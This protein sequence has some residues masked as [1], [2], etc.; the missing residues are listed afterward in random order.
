MT[1]NL[2][3]RRPKFVIPDRTAEG[4]TEPGHT[5]RRALTDDR[6]VHIFEM[7]EDHR[8]GDV[9]RPRPTATAAG[10]SRFVAAGHPG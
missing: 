9:R 5:A 7:C 10:G 6:N 2:R 3:F 8:W 1:A 4:G